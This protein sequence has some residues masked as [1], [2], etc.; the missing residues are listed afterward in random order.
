MYQLLFL[1]F[2]T[3][4]AICL[5]FGL[6]I[7]CDLLY[8]LFET[9]SGIISENILYYFT[10][11]FGEIQGSLE[12]FLCSAP[13]GLLFRKTAVFMVMCFARTGLLSLPIRG[14][15]FGCK[16]CAVPHGLLPLPILETTPYV[17]L[18]FSRSEIQRS[19]AGL[20]VTP[21][22]KMVKQAPPVGFFR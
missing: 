7:L 5:S 18:Y 10:T 13:H 1:F 9:E 14:N 16:A 17:M 15:C 21:G 4:I 2:F 3:A 12:I 6:V 19:R 8:N 20:K 11:S 22:G